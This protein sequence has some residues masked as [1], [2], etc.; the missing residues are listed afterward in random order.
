MLTYIAR[1]LVGAVGVLFVV[2]LVT[3]IIFFL[4]PSNPAVL[5][6]GRTSSAATIVATKKKLGLDKSVPVQYV[7]YVKGL[8]AGRDYSA[9][10]GDVSHCS[11]PC[12]GYSFKNNVA[13][14]SLIVDRLPVTISIALGAGVLW[15]AFGLLSGVLSA[16]RKGTVFDRAAMIVSLA[17]VSLPV[18]FTALLS[19]SVFSYQFNL[20]PNVHY[21]NLLDDPLMWARN[22][23][24]PWLT[25]AFL[26]AALYTRLTRASMLETMSEDYIR[27]ARA[28]GLAERTVVRRHALR[29]A[30]TPLVTVFGLDLGQLLGGAII[31]EK[32]FGFQGI[33]ALA[34]N[35]IDQSDLPI[36]IGVTL[37]AA[38]FIVMANL[39]VDIL[40]GV[41]DPRVR[42]A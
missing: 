22:L 19:L 30:L 38:F 3:Y 40:Y 39:L 37:I 24:L 14:R 15:L 2:T 35:A 31:T 5:Y 13:V 42:Y 25:L 32:A 17:G 6:S 7:Q 12:L 21:V 18:F 10:P 20:L 8:F 26:Y 23:L 33:G 27:T 1:R 11:A 4:V 34:I 36:V 29:A 28:K 41:I 16:L 9:G